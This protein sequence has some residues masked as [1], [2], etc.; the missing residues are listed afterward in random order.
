M[1]YPR[2]SRPRRWRVEDDGVSVPWL[3]SLLAVYFVAML[4]TS[5]WSGVTAMTP[6]AGLEA[7]L[8]NGALFVALAGAFAFAFNLLLVSG[9]GKPLVSVLLLVASVGAYALDTLDLRMTVASLGAAWDSGPTHLLRLPILW[10][11]GLFGVLPAAVLVWTRVGRR[12]L[13]RE[14]TRRVRYGLFCIALVVCAAA[15]QQ[16]QFQALW[17]A[18]SSLIPLLNPVNI[19]MMAASGEAGIP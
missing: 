12:K 6:Y 2:L 19:V 15:V 17:D 3:S 8:F 9:I 7:V 5:F 16:R 1:A 14:I 11:M 4:N 18:Q 10:K 13:P